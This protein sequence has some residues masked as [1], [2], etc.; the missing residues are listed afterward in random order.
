MHAGDER[1]ELQRACAA[2][3]GRASGSAPASVNEDDDA[4]ND[5]EGNSQD[6]ILRRLAAVFDQA[7]KRLAAVGRDSFFG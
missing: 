5:A 6:S 4:D 2:A 3:G 1:Y 7:R